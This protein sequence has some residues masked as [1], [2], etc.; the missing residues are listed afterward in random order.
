MPAMMTAAVT[1]APASASRRG[2]RTSATRPTAAGTHTKVALVKI[3][4]VQASAT[5][6]QRVQAGRSMARMASQITRNVIVL[7]RS[8][9]MSLDQ[10]HVTNGRP[11][12]RPMPHASSQKRECPTNR[13]S[14]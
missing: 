3:P 7:S 8:S 14:M 11:R 6:N 5:R 4:A 12:H 9:R 13:T 2:N 1:N 10:S